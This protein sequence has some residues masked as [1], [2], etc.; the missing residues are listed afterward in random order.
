VNCVSDELRVEKFFF[1]LFFFWQILIYYLFYPHLFFFTILILLHAWFSFWNSILLL[2]K[3][4][5]FSL[6]NPDL[7]FVQYP[8][9]FH[10]QRHN[11]NL[12]F[13]I[14]GTLH[15]SFFIRIL[16]YYLSNT[17]LFCESRK[18]WT[19]GGEIFFFVCLF[20]CLFFCLNPN[21]LFIQHPSFFHHRPHN[22]NI[23]FNIIDTVHPSFFIRILIYYSSNTHHF[24]IINV[25]ILIYYST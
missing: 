11:P 25:A 5:S 12:L 20:V 13:I 1:F 17:H 16:I 15:P 6:H 22:P 21:L 4:P 19:K 18:R 10:Y 2:I 7:L 3:Y 24:F 8:S 23:L 14:I 9:F